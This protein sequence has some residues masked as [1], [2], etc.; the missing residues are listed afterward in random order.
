MSGNSTEIENSSIQIC[1]SIPTNLHITHVIF[2]H[3][4]TLSVIRRGWETVMSEFMLEVL[5]SGSLDSNHIDLKIK[6]D[7][8]IAHT[9]G[10]RTLEQMDGL[11]AMI[12]E[13]QIFPREQ[14][15]NR[16]EYKQIYLNSLMKR[17]KK[18]LNDIQNKKYTANEFLIK[19][20][21]RFLNALKTYVKEIYLASGTDEQD[22]RLEATA[23]GLNTYFNGG[24]FGAKDALDYD[25]KSFVIEQISKKIGRENMSNTL[26][27]GD[28]PVEIREGRKWGAFTIGVASNEE[29]LEGINPEKKLRLIKAGAH[30]IIGDYQELDK[31]MGLLNFNS[32]VVGNAI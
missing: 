15:K 21:V 17:V 22:V 6:I 28:G 24:I 29:S 4:G 9:T 30:V 26:V 19:G 31:I 20:S 5:T 16:Y 13:L 7:E 25:I 3:D 32:G 23:L 27:I 10:I 18:N 12:Q 1:Q 2:D 14:I 11:I 8:F